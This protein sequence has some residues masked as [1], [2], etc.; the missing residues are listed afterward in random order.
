MPPLANVPGVLKVRLTWEVDGDTTAE[1]IHHVSY[2]G[3]P[4]TSAQCVT[5]ANSILTAC[6]S[7]FVA[8]MS[9]DTLVESVQIT[10]LTSATAGQ[11]TSTGSGTVGTRGTAL[12]SPG[13]AALVNHSISRRYRGGKPRTYFPFGVSGDVTTVGV[14]SGA[15]ITAVNAAY[16][17][18][19]S[20]VVG[21]GA[22]CTLTGFVNVS[23]YSG[24]TAVKE[25]SGRYRN[26]PNPR[27]TPLVDPFTGSALATHIGSQRRRNRKA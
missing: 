1:T 20:A 7:D 21:S 24:F 2:T 9:D 23:Y 14:W 8:L 12:L 3:G 17:T 5:M 13:T 6:N 26:V 27:S 25:S 18:W 4:P 16:A 10:D 19:Q 15:F 11:G 22:G